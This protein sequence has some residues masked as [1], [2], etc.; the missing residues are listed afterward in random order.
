[1]EIHSSVATYQ[2]IQQRDSQYKLQTSQQP[3]IYLQNNRKLHPKI[4]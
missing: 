1:M 2:G 3:T 4:N